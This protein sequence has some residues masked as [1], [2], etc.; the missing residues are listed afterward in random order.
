MEHKSKSRTTNDKF[1]KSALTL[2][3]IG[4]IC[5]V[6]LA[7]LAGTL[8]ILLPLPELSIPE[9]TRIYDANGDTISS[10]FV[11]NRVVLPYNKIPEH[12]KNAVIAVEDKRFFEHKGIDFHSL[13]RA[14]L[15]NFKAG[16]VVEGGSTITQQVAKN[17]FL[18]HDRTIKRKILE[19]VY[20]VQLEKQYSKQQILEMYLNIIYLG[21]GTYGCETASKLY[22]NKSATEM[23]LAESAMMAGIITGPEIYSPYHDIELAE[24]RKSIVLNL[25]VDQGMLDE[26]TAQEAK[27]QKI[28]TAGMPKSA[29]A[30]FV[31]FVLAE[32]RQTL[33]EVASEIYKGGYEVFTTLD[34]KIQTA[35]EKAFKEHLPKGAS[36]SR[37]IT[38]P[39]GALVAIEPYTGHV[40][41]LIGGRDFNETQLNRAYQV[42]RQPGSAFKVFLYAAVLDSGYPI[43]H[44][45]ICEPI[46]FPGNAPGDVYKPRDFGWPAYH[47]APLDIRQAIAIS[48]NVVAAKWASEIGPNKIIEYAKKLG[49]ESPLQANI[50]L[51]LGASEVTPMEMAGACAALSAQGIYT[52]PI[53]LLKLVDSTGNILLETQP[54]PRRVLN[55]D[56]AYMLTSCLRSV[57]STGGT[58]SGLERFLGNRPV[59]A[60]TGTTD[61]HLEAWLVGYTQQLACA[62]YVGWDN[63]EY[64]LSGTGASVAGPIWASFMGNALAKHPIRDWDLP[65]TLHWGK[66]CDKSGQR[67]NI[68][69]FDWHYEIFKNDASAPICSTNHLFEILLPGRQQS[70]SN[71]GQE[72]HPVPN[73][74]P[75][76]APTISTNR[77]GSRVGASF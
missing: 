35:A 30:Y 64:G 55:S 42:R 18:T 76:D 3:K 69:C 73:F 29:A 46:E 34:L 49:I 25:M 36:D 20:T 32:I 66:V 11:E 63:R 44:T 39:Q 16:E 77:R 24:K 43:N 57:F 8:F 47:Y 28:E 71:F 54:E 10:L 52:E 5:L 58:A 59:A 60:K 2:L 12:F 67:T 40:K 45:Q 14:L 13:G 21:H 37:G 27:E 31:D 38:Q 17:L 26:T 23:S 1:K 75:P 22:F 61:E 70:Q 15:R 65:E 68:T 33:P 74:T 51:A 48:D 7:A 53:A 50:P 4:I 56:T 6:L 72:S 19:A 9:A 41:A 62:V